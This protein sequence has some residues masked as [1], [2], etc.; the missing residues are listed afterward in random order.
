MS[1]VRSSFIVCWILKCLRR[2][3]STIISHQPQPQHA[4]CCCM[5][6]LGRGGEERRGEETRDKR[7][8]HGIPLPFLLS[9]LVGPVWLCDE[10]W[11]V[12]PTSIWP[13]SEPPSLTRPQQSSLLDSTF[14]ILEYWSIELENHGE[15]IT[16]QKV[17][18]WGSWGKNQGC[19]ER[20]KK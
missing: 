9:Q 4:G 2:W 19:H 12:Q 16:I 18:C 11:L 15:S 13:R 14:M 6:R 20:K 5:L 7:Q 17:W 1:V 8:R 3:R 10:R